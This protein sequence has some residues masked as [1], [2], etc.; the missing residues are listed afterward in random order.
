MEQK[1]LDRITPKTNSKG[2]TNEQKSKR[3]ANQ[4]IMSIKNLTI[5]GALV[6]GATVLS[7]LAVHQYAKHLQGNSAPEGIFE[8]SYKE[9]ELEPLLSTKIQ[10]TEDV[11]EEHQTQPEQICSIPRDKHWTDFFEISDVAYT[12]F[13]TYPDVNSTTMS[14]L[15]YELQIL[16][17]IQQQYDSTSPDSS[18]EEFT[19]ETDDRTSYLNPVVPQASKTPM[20]GYR[21][22]GI[23][24]VYDIEKLGN[25][26]SYVRFD[27]IKE[28]MNS[29]NEEAS[30]AREIN[31]ILYQPLADEII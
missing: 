13:L 29:Q 30:K 16:Q 19:L 21:E 23:F 31:S 11:K 15:E 5:A 9:P 12:C 26:S 10:L 20:E 14:E 4:E 22:Q 17:D 1:L 24:N 25:S 8:Q 2:L 3:K 18:P 28:D 7:P 6:A 27:D